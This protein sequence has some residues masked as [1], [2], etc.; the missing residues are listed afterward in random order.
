M[1]PVPSEAHSLLRDQ[2]QVWRMLDFERCAS[3]IAEAGRNQHPAFIIEAHQSGVKGC[4]PQ[5]RE[6]QAI[7]HVEPFGIAFADRPRPYM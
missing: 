3:F 1:H 7:M 4:I 5:A 6:Q 2:E